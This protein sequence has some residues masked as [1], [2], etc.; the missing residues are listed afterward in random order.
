MYELLPL[1]L[2]SPE[3]MFL[4]KLHSNNLFNNDIV[5]IQKPC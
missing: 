5:F 1:V 3:T 2:P 4:F